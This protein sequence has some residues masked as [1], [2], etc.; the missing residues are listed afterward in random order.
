MSTLRL[1]RTLGSELGISMILPTHCRAE[2]RRIPIRFGKTKS[3]EVHDLSRH[4]A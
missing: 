3:S 2:H 4:I 1:F